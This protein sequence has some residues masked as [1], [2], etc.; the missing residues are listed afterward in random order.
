[1]DFQD[2]QS[3][4]W[5]HPLAH[6]ARGAWAGAVWR[7]KGAPHCGGHWW[8]TG[9]V[10]PAAPLFCL[11]NSV[12]DR[13][14]VCA[15][16]SSVQHSHARCL[17]GGGR[18]LTLVQHVLPCRTGHWWSMPCK[19]SHFA[20]VGKPSQNETKQTKQG[21][22]TDA[23]NAEKTSASRDTH[24]AVGVPT[25]TRHV[26]RKRY[27]VSGK[28][29]LLGWGRWAENATGW[30]VQEKWRIAAGTTQ[31]NVVKCSHNACFFL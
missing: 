10:S 23:S 1:M 19:W 28:D 2:I 22:S 3:A 29:A 18:G 14:Q 4:W 24:C 31:W 7:V 6:V 12:N 17:F 9:F 11:V 30:I 13:Y 8:S 25:A 16:K 26:G 20:V 5:T 15:V 27:S 21:L